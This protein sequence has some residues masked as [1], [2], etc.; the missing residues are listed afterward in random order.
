M[1]S[2]LLILLLA[3]ALV[4]LACLNLIDLY[5]ARNLAASLAGHGSAALMDAAGRDLKQAVENYARTVH[6]ESQ[7]LELALRNQAREVEARLAQPAPRV[8]EVYFSE[9][10]DR[11]ERI[12]NRLIPSVKHSKSDAAGRRFPGLISLE[13]VDVQSPPEVD[14]NSHAGDIARLASMA[15]VY[16][17]IWAAYSDMLVGMMT[18]L[19]GGL[20]SGY[21]GIGGYPAEYDA[22]NRPWYIQAK[23]KRRLAWN[24][25]YVDALSGVVVG[26]L[27]MPVHGPDGSFAGVT[28]MDVCNIQGFRAPSFDSKWAGQCTII[29]AI[30]RPRPEGGEP[31]LLVVGK[32]RDTGEALDWRVPL[33]EEWLATSDRARYG[34]MIEDLMVRRTGVIGMPFE[35]RAS[36][37]AYGAI[38]ETEAALIVIVP[39]QAVVAAAL[40]L[41]RYV[42]AQAD[43]YLKYILLVAA[44]TSLFVIVL[45][46]R[47]SR[48][49]AEPLRALSN[50]TEDIAR[51]DLD[52]AVPVIRSGDE[53]GGLA[54]SVVRM[55]QDLKRYIKD[56]TQATAARERME[57][58]LKIARDIQMSFLPKKLPGSARRTGFDMDALL[59]PAREV[60]GDFYDFFPVGERRVF[61]AIGDVSGKGVPAALFM[62]L[63]KSLMKGFARDSATPSEILARMNR[64]LCRDNE[65][66]M[67]VS[68]LCG[69]LDGNTGE[70]LFSNAGHN[71]P[72]LLRPGKR[73][74]VL[75]THHSL[76]L[77]GSD[78]TGYVTERL[79]MRPGDGLFLYT[80]GLTEARCETGDFFAMDRLKRELAALD[81]DAPREAVRKLMA[82]GR[83][84]CG[85]APQSDDIAML[86]IRYAG[87]EA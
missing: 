58:E 29:L 31:S 77:G 40:E 83:A 25:P 22:R 21:P 47:A 75:R 38:G 81:E 51:G 37:W 66:H 80:D 30:M 67:F 7:V 87:P 41:K 52:A 20:M 53:I 35:D 63:T 44:L 26:S 5:L 59:I 18:A 36:L 86:M 12:P 3:V 57:S 65:T 4:P 32:S 33:R 2:K 50:F 11:R 56:L 78:D 72:V 19:E 15:P 6:R 61:F 62:A 43:R 82:A 85:D 76:V 23:E 84:F 24:A 49:V 55:K 8:R 42:L 69:I 74:E 46:H 10:Y 45:A 64:E 1:Y 17:E 60:G 28:A 9:D 14:R 48:A 73:P 27:S 68:V 71:P 13:H 39:E 16:Q 70:V 54:R 34:G 79:A